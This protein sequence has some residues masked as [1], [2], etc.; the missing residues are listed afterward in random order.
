MAQG[1]KGL[2]VGKVDPG[3]QLRACQLL[4]VAAFPRQVGLPGAHLLLLLIASSPCRWQH[5]CFSVGRHPRTWSYHMVT[6]PSG[7]E[8]CTASAHSQGPSTDFW[9]KTRRN[10]NLQCWRL[11]PGN[12]RKHKSTSNPYIRHSLCK[13]HSVMT[14][15]HAVH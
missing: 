5:H 7:I 15:H 6:G 3:S 9:S 4:R 8:T 14:Y 13:L 2:L 12:H 11:H 1:H 10:R